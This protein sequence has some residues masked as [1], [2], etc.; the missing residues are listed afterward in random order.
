MPR[1]SREN[2]AADSFD[3]EAGE[4]DGAGEL[5]LDDDSFLRESVT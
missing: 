2:Y 1:G 3:G 5:S 4:V